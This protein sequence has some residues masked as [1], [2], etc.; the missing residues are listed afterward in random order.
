VNLRLSTGYD[1]IDMGTS[2]REVSGRNGGLDQF[3]LDRDGRGQDGLSERRH[4]GKDASDMSFGVT[5]IGRDGPTWVME[6]FDARSEWIFAEFVVALRTLGL[7]LP[8]VPDPPETG[9]VVTTT[10]E[11]ADVSVGYSD[12]RGCHIFSANREALDKL[13]RLTQDLP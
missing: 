13:S 7:P 12:D 6:F 8:E 4:I 10:W 9:F 3:P 5:K 1:L 11:G 2:S